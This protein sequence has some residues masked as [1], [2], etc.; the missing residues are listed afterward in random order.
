[1]FEKLFS[2]KEVTGRG[3]AHLPMDAVARHLVESPIYQEMRK[4]DPVA[5]QAACAGCLGL[6]TPY[7]GWMENRSHFLAGTYLDNEKKYLHLGVDIWVKEGTAVVA[8][9]CLDFVGTYFDP[10]DSGGW[11]GVVLAQDPRN[12][13]LTFL[14]AH[15]SSMG[16]ASGDLSQGQ[17]IGRVASTQYNGG[18]HPHLHIQVI[19]EW[20]TKDRWPELH[21][22]ITKRNPSPREI[23]SII[24]GYTQETP[25]PFPF[26]ASSVFP[27]PLPLLL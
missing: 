21:K 8:P 19:D 15:L 2:S 9:V 16:M 18:W 5:F 14:F 17:L 10:D 20:A 11:G 23:L 24:D 22:A 7:G 6:T 27:D 1:M 26:W 13:S 3:F 4:S 25:G 12:P